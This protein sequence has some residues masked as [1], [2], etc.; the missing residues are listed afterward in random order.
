MGGSVRRSSGRLD[1]QGTV[2]GASVAA[3]PS[4]LDVAADAGLDSERRARVAWLV[5]SIVSDS[6]LAESSLR[7]AA[8]GWASSNLPQALADFGAQWLDEG[9]LRADAAIALA[10]QV[11]DAAGDLETSIRSIAMNDK[12]VH[13][14]VAASIAESLIHGED[15]ADHLKQAA[16]IDDFVAGEIEGEFEILPNEP[17]AIARRIILL[18]LEEANTTP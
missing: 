15:G 11:S 5:A 17:T 3:L 1:H 13:R 7:T 12:N 9:G 16:S 6:L 8:E 14:Q 4:L 2:S 10:A 18:L